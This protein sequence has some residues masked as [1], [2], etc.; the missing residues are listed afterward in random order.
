MLRRLGTLAG[1]LIVFAFSFPAFDADAPSQLSIRPDTVRNLLSVEDCL[2]GR[3]CHQRLGPFGGTSVSGVSHGA[4]FLH[5]VTAVF[6]LGGD[7]HTVFHAAAVLSALGVVLL[8]LMGQRFAGFTA[9]LAAALACRLLWQD[10]ANHVELWNTLLL[11]FPGALYLFASACYLASR[12]LPL[13]L[14]AAF[15]VALGAQLHVAFLLQLL[16]LLYLGATSPIGTRTWRTLLALGLA[17]ALVKL[18]TPAI[19]LDVSLFGSGPLHIGVLAPPSGWV[20]PPRIAYVLLTLFAGA[21][22]WLDRREWGVPHRIALFLL[23]IFMP[24]ILLFS[25]LAPG[26]NRYIVALLPGAVW[27]LCATLSLASLRIWLRLAPLCTAT[28]RSVISLAIFL[29][30]PAAVIVAMPFAVHDATERLTLAHRHRAAERPTF[31]LEQAQQVADFAVNELHWTYDDAFRHLRGGRRHWDLLN[32]L[33]LHLAT[34]PPARRE[35]TKDLAVF[36]LPWT[37]PSATL[38]PGWSLIA[39]SADETL[40]GR[41]YNPW[42]QWDRFEICG[43]SATDPKPCVWAPLP[44]RRQVQ[45]DPR[46]A[47]LLAARAIPALPGFPQARQ[48]GALLLRV[49]VHIPANAAPRT[50]IALSNAPDA[51]DHGVVLAVTGVAFEG[52]LLSDAITLRSGALPT[53]GTVVLGWDW[54]D[55]YATQIQMPAPVLELESADLPLYKS[56]SL[57][58][59]GVAA[60][61]LARPERLSPQQWSTLAQRAMAPQ[62]APPDLQPPQPSRFGREPLLPLW[63]TLLFTALLAIG[64]LL[65]VLACLLCRLPGEDPPPH[66]RGAPRTSLLMLPFLLLF[67]LAS[68]SEASAAG[69]PLIKPADAN[70]FVTLLAPAAMDG[71]F[72]CGYT[73]SGLAVDRSVVRYVFEQGAS[74]CEFALTDR[75][76]ARAGSVQVGDIA[77][78]PSCTPAIGVQELELQRIFLARLQSQDRLLRL[79]AE[80]RGANP[81]AA[82]RHP[83][84]VR[85]APQPPLVSH[86]LTGLVLLLVFALVRRGGRPFVDALLVSLW[87]ALCLAFQRLGRTEPSSLRLLLLALTSGHAAISV[88]VRFQI[89]QFLALRPRLGRSLRIAA[90]LAIAMLTL[91]Y[92][93]EL[94]PQTRPTTLFRSPLFNPELVDPVHLL[95][96]AAGLL[97]LLPGRNTRLV[98]AFLPLCALVLTLSVLRP[99]ASLVRALHNAPAWLLLFSLVAAG[100]LAINQRLAAQPRKLLTVHLLLSMPLLWTQFVFYV[101]SGRTVP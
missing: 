91:A 41:S 32:G 57:L 61:G 43:T 26:E 14:A 54:S 34:Q 93:A 9:G 21:L 6:W 7:W 47:Q 48:G 69:M 2:A 82:S 4:L 81:P 45:V 89:A 16:G 3:A 44:Y 72:C 13:L 8:F 50:L 83:P 87:L 99:E 38:P 40:L 67:L 70:R 39:R 5:F 36:V 30:L 73:F 63:F 64:T 51:A 18:G 74:R 52:P 98:L 27:L 28:Q 46:D 37:R 101:V 22:L 71:P 66:S 35:T 84:P 1:C 49:P 85:A 76:V 42:L 55:A 77:V 60:L 95:L 19:L 15:A 11:Q 24:S 75:A 96:A 97:A 88:A 68:P 56:A 29:A 94:P 25:W 20:G 33:A 12:R 79:L 58:G 17:I 100:V 80:L 78:T 53:E 90:L 59:G 86:L 62:P 10:M 92:V 23:V 31:N 65:A